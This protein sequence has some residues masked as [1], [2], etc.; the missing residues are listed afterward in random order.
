MVIDPKFSLDKY[1]ELF[2]I[3]EA[4]KKIKVQSTVLDDT[5]K[6]IKTIFLMN[7]WRVTINIRRRWVKFL[8][9]GNNLSD[10]VS[11]QLGMP[12]FNSLFGKNNKW[13]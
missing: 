10:R 9:E 3:N 8:F 13:I 5:Y 11:Y 2:N 7:S 1:A 4:M 6:S 12:L